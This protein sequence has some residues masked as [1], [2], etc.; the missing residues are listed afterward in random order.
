MVIL[1]RER[2][3]KTKGISNRQKEREERCKKTKKKVRKI[4]KKRLMNIEPK[5]E[6]MNNKV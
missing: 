3:N 6:R 1:N 4:K 5:N 2:E